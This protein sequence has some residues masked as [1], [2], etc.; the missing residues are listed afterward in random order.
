MHTEK[1]IARTIQKKGTSKKLKKGQREDISRKI[2]H[3]VYR[4]IISTPSGEK[5]IE[6]T[7]IDW[8]QFLKISSSTFIR[9][10]YVYGYSDPRMLYTKDEMKSAISK[11]KSETAP[12]KW[13]EVPSP[14]KEL[15]VPKTSKSNLTFTRASCIELAAAVIQNAK[16]NL[17]DL[18]KRE[19]MKDG[20]FVNYYGSR[21]FLMDGSGNLSFWLDLADNIDTK[22]ARKAL[23]AYAMQFPPIHPLDQNKT[24]K[25]DCQTYQHML[26]ISYNINK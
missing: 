8:I 6:K 18:L 4:K 17:V 26:Y 20:D 2:L 14:P 16:E 11:K 21:R 24:N 13:K 3:K 5:I 25:L 22:T 15:S 9:R 10:Y 12:S 7:G 19:P 1:T 23:Y